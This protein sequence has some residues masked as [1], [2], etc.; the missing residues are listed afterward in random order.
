[1]LKSLL[2]L[3]LLP[4]FCLNAIGKEIP[5]QYSGVTGPSGWKCH[6]IQSDPQDH[7]PDGM[8]WHD[9]NEDGYPDVFINYEEGKTSRLYFNPGPSKIHQP[10]ENYIEFKHGPCEDSGFG[11]LDNDGDMDYIANGGHIYFNPGVEKVKNVEAWKKITLSPKEGRAPIVTDID[12]DGLNDLL[13]AGQ[14]WYK[15]PSSN[16]HQVENWKAYRLGTAKWVMNNIPY[17]V[18]KDGLTDI[19]VQDRR[20][21]VFW[22]QNPGQDKLTQPW[23]RHSIFKNND[24]MFMLIHDINM[25]QKDDFIITCGRGGNISKKVILLLRQNK[26][27]FPKFK[28]IRLDPAQT[29]YFNDIDY[30]PKGLAHIHVD[31]DP[32]NQ[33]VLFLPKKGDMWYIS[34]KGDAFQ[35]RIGPPPLSQHQALSRERKWTTF[36]SVTLT[37]MATS[38]SALQKKMEAGV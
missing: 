14:V 5:Q 17:D 9:W 4:A 7:G 27:G 26:S 35:K 37:K 8:N 34:H 31:E 3:S 29:P 22:Y 15:Q 24:S 16:P 1:M 11:D 25:D 18:D 20:N 32:N 10:W 19:V 6:I 13:V 33:E 38:T 28:E 36:I 12:Q 2:Q 21:E 30:F 23:P